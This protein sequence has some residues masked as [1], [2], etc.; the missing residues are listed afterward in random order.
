MIPPRIVLARPGIGENIGFVV[1][2]LA[3]F[4]LDELVLADP[5]AGFERG[6]A[7]TASMCPERLARVRVVGDAASALLD[8][9]HVFGF[10]ARGGRERELL[11]LA[12]LGALASG[13]PRGARVAFLFGNEE[14]GLTSEETGYC[15]RL[16]TIPLPGLGSLNLSHAVALVLYEYFRAGQ[17]AAPDSRHRFASTG[18]KQRLAEQARATLGT[19]AFAVDDPHFE[20]SVRRLLFGNPIQA[21]DTRILHRI[22]RHLD[23]VRNHGSN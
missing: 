11:P 12:E 9:S 8:T 10:S 20:G 17:A 23:Y 16:L 5:A 19:W 3:N 21:R 14:S 18:E 1:R 22:L 13:I 6:A 7:R 15:H 4:E 2:L